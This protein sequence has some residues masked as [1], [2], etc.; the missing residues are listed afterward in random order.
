M[1][2]GGELVKKHDRTIDPTV[3]NLG[4]CSCSAVFVG[5]HVIWNVTRRFTP[6]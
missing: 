6:R 2:R 4:E 1:A 5:Y 3:V